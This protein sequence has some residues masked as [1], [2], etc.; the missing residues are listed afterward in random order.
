MLQRGF[1]KESIPTYFQVVYSLGRQYSRTKN[2]RQRQMYRYFSLYIHRSTR[3]HPHPGRLEVSQPLFHIKFLSHCGVFSPL[4]FRSFHKVPCPSISQ[5]W[6]LEI[7]TVAWRSAFSTLTLKRHW[8]DLLIL[9]C[10]FPLIFCKLTLALKHPLS[11]TS[12]HITSFN[13]ERNLFS[14]YEAH[15]WCLSFTVSTN[16]QQ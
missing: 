14:S 8:T 16:N 10:G 9:T 1:C 6:L 12:H 3:R 15:F 4:H 7:V 11:L 5:R 13:L 2:R